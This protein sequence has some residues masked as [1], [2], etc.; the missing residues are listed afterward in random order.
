MA[1]PGSG[2]VRGGV[3]VF[4]LRVYVE[5]TDAAGVVYYM[6]YLR[7]TERARTEMMRLAGHRHSS[8]M[9]GEAGFPLALAVRRCESDYLSP[10]R[11]DDALEVHSRLVALGGASMEFDQAVVRDEEPIMRCRVRIACIRLDTGRPARIPREVRE[12]LK[13]FVSEVQ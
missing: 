11:L 6:N 12:T 2:V 5:D 3:H 8:L 7:Y 4:P 10:A 13:I 1:E 9:A